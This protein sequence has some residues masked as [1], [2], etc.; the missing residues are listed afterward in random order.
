MSH[1]YLIEKLDDARY[2]IFTSEDEPRNHRGTI[3]YEKDLKRFAPIYLRSQLKHLDKYK[4]ENDEYVLEKELVDKL[5]YMTEMYY[6]SI[7]SRL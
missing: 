3:I 7:E 6:K 1:Y 2:N 4:N 5:M